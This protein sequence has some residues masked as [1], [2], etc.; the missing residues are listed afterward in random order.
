MVMFAK[1]ETRYYV[2][3][4]ALRGELAGSRLLSMI[5]PKLFVV[6]GLCFIQFCVFPLSLNQVLMR[7]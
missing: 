2:F 6:A 7:A 5:A 1:M 3:K 4:E